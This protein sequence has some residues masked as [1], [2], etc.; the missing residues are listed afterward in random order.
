MTSEFYTELLRWSWI[1]VLTCLIGWLTNLLAVRLLFRPRRPIGFGR[2]HV[3]GVVPRRREALAQRIGDIV[4]R[5]L[6]SQ[7][8]IRQ[9]LHRI[10]LQAYLDRFV[11]RFVR[12][13][14]SPKLR[15]IPVV[16]GLLDKGT[17]HTLEYLARDAMRDEL[18]SIRDKMAEDLEAHLPVRALVTQRVNDFDL[19]KLEALA[20]QVAAREFKMI[21]HLGAALGLVVGIVQIII[22]AALH[23]G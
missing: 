18:E 23:T 12:G 9:Q 2:W 13:R 10:D 14:L 17:L 4:E 5:E 1:P 22:M 19:D 11:R 6:L 15:R 21:E 20:F 8:V 7:H 3:Q 16:G